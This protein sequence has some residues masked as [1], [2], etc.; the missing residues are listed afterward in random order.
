MIYT[1]INFDVREE[2]ERETVSE[3]WH[4]RPGREVGGPGESSDE[5]LRLGEEGNGRHERSDGEEDAAV[6]CIGHMEKTMR[7]GWLP[8]PWRGAGEEVN[9]FEEAREDNEL[10]VLHASPEGFGS[11]CGG[12]AHGVHLTL[13]SRS[14]KEQKEAPGRGFA[15][16]AAPPALAAR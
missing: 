16:E 10:W 7:S 4:S 3:R 15:R 2:R 9:K 12:W 6:V 11:S 1:K 13:S 8:S 14:T 5:L